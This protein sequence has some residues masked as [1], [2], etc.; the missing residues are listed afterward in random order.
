MAQTGTIQF[1]VFTSSANIPI[2]SATVIVRGQDAP[3]T[4]F[5]IL[6][7]DDSGQTPILTIPARAES[8]GQTSGSDIKPWVG[9]RVYIEHPDYETVTFEGVQLFP[10]VLS[11]QNVQLVPNQEIDP[12]EDDLQEYDLTPQPIW[13]GGSR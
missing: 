10:R 2:E 3:Y 1:R 5:G 11:I 13:E 8:L 4:L 9:L 7:T 12:Q 6:V